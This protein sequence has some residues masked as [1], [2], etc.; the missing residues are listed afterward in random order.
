MFNL[1]W[2]YLTSIHLIIFVPFLRS[3]STKHDITLN[4][5]SNLSTSKIKAIVA[6]VPCDGEILQWNTPPFL[7]PLLFSSQELC[8]YMQEEGEAWKHS[9]CRVAN[10]LLHSIAKQE[11]WKKVHIL[12][13]DSFSSCC[14]QDI[15]KRLSIDFVA[16]QLI[17]VGLDESIRSLVQYVSNTNSMNIFY[18]VDKELMINSILQEVLM[19]V[20]I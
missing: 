3:S 20:F 17:H 18:V 19:I 13:D 9:D 15:V 12:Y 5:V 7:L 4:I 11:M 1:V 6:S 8:H 2:T 16:S 14:L 10:E